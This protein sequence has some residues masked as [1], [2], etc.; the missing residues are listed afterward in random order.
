MTTYTIK[1]FNKSKFSKKINETDERWFVSLPFTVL[2]LN[3]SD[4]I[5]LR[6]ED[7]NLQNAKGQVVEKI[8][9]ERVRLAEHKEWQI[10][11]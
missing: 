4:T 10:E 9:A 8:K 6:Q 5:L 11:V 1:T 2:E 7:F 3:Y